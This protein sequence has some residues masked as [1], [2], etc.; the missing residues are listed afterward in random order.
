MSVQKNKAFLLL[1]ILLFK[2][3]TACSSSID[4]SDQAQSTITNMPAIESTKTSMPVAKSTE[5]PESTSEPSIPI[6]IPEG[7]NVLL[8]IRNYY[9]EDMSYVT[10]NELNEMINM[11]EDVDFNVWV[12][13]LSYDPYKSETKT[14]TPDFL[15][16]SVD[17]AD[18]DAVILPCLAAGDSPS[19]TSKEIVDLVKEFDEQEKVIAAVHGARYS[20]FLEKII[21][22]DQFSGDVVQKGRIITSGCCPYGVSYYECEDGTRPLIEKVITTLNESK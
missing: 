10:D 2:F 3:G 22:N 21:D 16:N 5:I 9:S 19:S 13:S 1:F 17:V 6:T 4:E 18:F 7:T 20:L 15:I 8:V 14:I 11:L 12:T